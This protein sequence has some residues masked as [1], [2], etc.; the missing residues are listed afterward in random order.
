MAEWRLYGS[1]RKDSFEKE[2]VP[3]ELAYTLMR[4]QKELGMEFGVPELLELE[5]IKALALIAEAINDAP[6]FLLDN[7]GRAVKEG[8]FSSVPE[9]LESIADAILDQ[10]T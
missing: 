7:V 8:I 2:L 9:A 4:Y 10:N 5:K 6:E 1:D 3:D